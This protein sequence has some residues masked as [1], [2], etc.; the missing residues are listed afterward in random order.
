MVDLKLRLSRG[1]TRKS[2]PVS[3]ING[4]EKR[5][6]GLL[7]AG[8]F[9]VLQGFATGR[10]GREPTNQPGGGLGRV[11]YAPI[12]TKFH[13]AAKC[14]VPKAVIRERQLFDMLA[15]ISRYLRADEMGFFP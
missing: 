7:P 3:E 1:K 2:Q 13:M 10:S 15:P 9:R 8:A 4:K 11:R 5:K 14:D 12:A 6:A